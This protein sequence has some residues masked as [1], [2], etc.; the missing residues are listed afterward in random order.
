MLTMLLPGRRK[1]TEKIHWGE[2]RDAESQRDRGEW[3]G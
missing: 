2:G 1:S 3:Q